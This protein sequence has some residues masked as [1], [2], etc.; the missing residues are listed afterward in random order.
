MGPDGCFAK[1]NVPLGTE[2]LQVRVHSLDEHHRAHGLQD[3]AVERRPTREVGRRA[4]SCGECDDW[5]SVRLGIRLED[6]TGL[7]SI[8]TG[9]T[10]VHEHEV[11]TQGS[12]DR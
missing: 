8:D 2:Q 10:D 12:S 9:K 11:W 1:S 5:D 6:V 4:H 3:E 7:P